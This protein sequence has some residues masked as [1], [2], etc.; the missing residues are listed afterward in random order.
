MVFAGWMPADSLERKG[1]KRKQHRYTSERAI[2][3]DI[4]AAQRK[5]TALLFEAESHDMAAMRLIQASLKS[6]LNED[7]VKELEWQKGLAAKAR[8][9]AERLDGVVA[10]LRAT[11]DAFATPALPGVD[12]PTSVVIQKP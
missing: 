6:P 1:M 4:Y 3:A 2:L 9:A 12:V 8:R 10:K 11:Q 7:D 5:K